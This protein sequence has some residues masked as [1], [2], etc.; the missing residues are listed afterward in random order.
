M[1][2]SSLKTNADFFD[3]GLAILPP[4]I[5]WSN[6]P[7][8]WDEASFGQF[9]G[10]TTIVAGSTVILVLLFTA[11]AGYAAIGYFVIVYT[12]FRGKVA[13]PGEH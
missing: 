13:G 3:Q 7:N 11:M 4:Q 6:Y 2:G 5:E 9:F 8:A 10:N 1:L 12:M